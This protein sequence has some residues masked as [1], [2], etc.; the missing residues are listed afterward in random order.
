MSYYFYNLY[1]SHELIE[2]AFSWDARIYH[3]YNELLKSEHDEFFNSNIRTNLYQQTGREYTRFV[4]NVVAFLLNAKNILNVEFNE[5]LL[6]FSTKSN[7]LF[8]ATITFVYLL[9][10]ASCTIFFVMLIRNA[11]FKSEAFNKQQPTIAIV[12]NQHY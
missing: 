12:S 11:R 6:Q 9:V 10:L 4:T 3:R 8:Y 2:S 1:S 5:I 7:L